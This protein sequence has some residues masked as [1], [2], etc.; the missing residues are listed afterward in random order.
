M[1]IVPNGVVLLVVASLLPDWFFIHLLPIILSSVGLVG[2]LGESPVAV[3]VPTSTLIVLSKNQVHGLDDCGLLEGGCLQH[4]ELSL[5]FRQRCTTEEVPTLDFIRK[6]H[7]VC[8]ELPV[9]LFV[10]IDVGEKRLTREP[11]KT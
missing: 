3:V 5:F 8:Q 2:P 6:A 4:Q 10:V 11:L 7:L 9:G 1:V